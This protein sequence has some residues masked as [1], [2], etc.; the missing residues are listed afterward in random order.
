M[1]RT[2][3]PARLTVMLLPAIASVLWMATLPPLPQPHTYHAFADSRSWLGVANFQDVASNL[4]FL[5]HLLAALAVVL[6]P[7]MLV[8]RASSESDPERAS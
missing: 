8:Q 1:T 6:V 4:P 2:R 5:K 7:H 3:Y